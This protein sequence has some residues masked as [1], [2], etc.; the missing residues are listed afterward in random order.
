M[1]IQ[2]AVCMYSTAQVND[3]CCET[4]GECEEKEEGGICKLSVESEN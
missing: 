2:S 1:V 3:L 4:E